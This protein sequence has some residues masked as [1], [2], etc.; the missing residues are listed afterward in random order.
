TLL[1]RIG[2]VTVQQ[3]RAWRR[4]AIVIAFVAAAILTPPDII[5]QFGLAIPTILLYEASILSVRFVERRR[6]REE[7]AR[8]AA[9]AT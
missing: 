4:Y 1:A 5:S 7:A 2:V 9:E 6:A 8:A 3:L